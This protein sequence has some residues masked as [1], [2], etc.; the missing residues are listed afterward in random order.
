[1]GFQRKHSCII[2]AARAYSLR[3]VPS[4]LRAPASVSSC[5]SAM[6]L[7][8]CYDATTRHSLHTTFTFA[9]TLP[10]PAWLPHAV[11]VLVS[12]ARIAPP[13]AKPVHSLRVFRAPLLTSSPLSLSASLALPSKR[14]R[15]RLDAAGEP[16]SRV[17]GGADGVRD[18][19]PV[20]RPQRAR[21]SHV[22][23]CRGV[24]LDV[25]ELPR[26]ESAIHAECCQPGW[27]AL[28]RHRPGKTTTP[29][30]H[31]YI[32]CPATMHL[33]L[34]AHERNLHV[35]HPFPR[36]T[37][38]LFPTTKAPPTPPAPPAPPAPLAP[39]AINVQPWRWFYHELC[40][41]DA[42]GAVLGYITRTCSVCSRDYTISDR[43]R[44]P[45]LKIAGP[46][47]TPWTFNIRAMVRE[48]GSERERKL[49][50]ES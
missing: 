43:D 44:Q 42:A 16:E 2:L 32:W 6:A 5:P 18:R 37:Q 33:C 13:H 31:C 41:K 47:Y 23:R 24:Q 19:K 29:C 3:A 30:L 11:E 22:P 9:C 21:P 45:I 35:C 27:V 26:E 8:T 17:H 46:C 40:V 10:H 39:L 20:H 1:M 28:P 12:F 25:A 48:R 36:S 49:E 34:S 14:P 4:V 38:S 7:C 50:R 15:W